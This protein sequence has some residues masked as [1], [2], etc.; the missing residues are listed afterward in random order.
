MVG[1]KR[2]RGK[3]MCSGSHRFWRD[4][5]ILGPMQISEQHRREIAPSESGAKYDARATR[6][7][8]D[9]IAI[10]RE[11]S[12]GYAALNKWMY[13]AKARGMT[14]LEGLYFSIDEMAKD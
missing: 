4:V 6:V 10:S 5:R 13:V 1:G 9:A 12:D 2:S 8:K 14:W 3:I 11:Q 7:L